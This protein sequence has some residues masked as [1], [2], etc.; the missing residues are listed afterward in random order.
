MEVGKGKLYK[1][2]IIPKLNE[3]NTVHIFRKD[4]M[5]RKC[6]VIDHIAPNQET[7]QKGT[8]KRRRQAQVC[9]QWLTG[10]T[11]SMF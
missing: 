2:T 6:E 5:G 3:K 8:K 4:T 9:P 1:Y 10:F 11:S 7:K